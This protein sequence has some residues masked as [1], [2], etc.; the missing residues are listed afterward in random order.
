MLKPVSCDHLTSPNYD[1]KKVRDVGLTCQRHL[2][3]I[4][5]DSISHE[6]MRQGITCSSFCARLHFSF[7]QDERVGISFIT[8]TLVGMGKS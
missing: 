7:P 6:S 3:N 4:M 1:E 2:S 8:I 5:S